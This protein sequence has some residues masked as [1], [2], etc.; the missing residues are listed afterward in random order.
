MKLNLFPFVLTTLLIM[1][2]G[3]GNNISRQVK[4]LRSDTALSNAHVGI[5][6]YS[7]EE[8]KFI[9]NYNSDK[10]FVPA[11]TTKLFSLYAGMK[12]I[13]DSIKAFRYHETEDTLYIIPTGDPTLLH[14]DFKTN[15]GLNF[16]INKGKPI[17]ILENPKTINPYGKGWAIDDLSES[18]AAQRNQ[19]P[20]FGNILD[21]E[22]KKNTANECR[23]EITK[24]TPL[25]I[26]NETD[27]SFDTTKNFSMV[28]VMGVNK[29]RITFNTDS[30]N[31]IQC[32]VPFETKGINTT[33]EVLSELLSKKII[34]RVNQIN[35]SLLIELKS[36]PSDSLYTIMMH[37]SD[38]FLAEQTLL[39]SSNQ[40]LGY[41]S[42]YDMINSMLNNDFKDIPQKP[43]WVDGSGLSRYNL[44]SPQ[45]FTYI[46]NKLI[47]EFGIERL[48]R[49][50]P[51]GG[52]G[53]LSNYY[54]EDKDFI[55][56]KTGTISGVA[57]LSG[58]MST[59]KNKLLLFSVM[60]NN[61]TGPSRPIKKFV[62]KFLH[63]VRVNN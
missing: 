59:S 37:R 7:P 23:Y 41:F 63:E 18:Y 48:K 24:A 20:V 61:F 1:S 54:L 8:N 49:I 12:Y 25:L 2:C 34:V 56:A 33:A 53:T 19:M 9:C 29:Y 60:I 62:E 6:I 55:Y 58:L 4:I 15:P 36:Q 16:L 50:L 43:K 17:V 40:K 35:N 38:N 39:M 10:Y 31:K 13:G 14:P 21:I 32:S 51:T 11:S 5:S 57:T 28:K 3:I 47:K 22:W 52:E 45:D 42:D 26:D 44:F 46:I 30:L 27:C